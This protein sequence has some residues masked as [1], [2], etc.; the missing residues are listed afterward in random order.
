MSVPTQKSNIIPVRF[1][2]HYKQLF[3][4]AHEELCS[5]SNFVLGIRIPVSIY[6]ICA[7]VLAFGDC[8]PLPADGKCQPNALPV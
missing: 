7:L 1:K 2:D 4:S 6:L 8:N 3:N 5:E